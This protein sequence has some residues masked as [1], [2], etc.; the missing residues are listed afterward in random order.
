[1]DVHCDGVMREGVLAKKESEEHAGY[2]KMEADMAT[3]KVLNKDILY[4]R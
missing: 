2:R 1:M 3:A 4:F